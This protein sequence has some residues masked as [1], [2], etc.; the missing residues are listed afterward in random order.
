[1]GC[2]LDEFYSNCALLI[3]SLSTIVLY[4][5]LSSLVAICF[6]SVVSDQCGFQLQPKGTFAVCKTTGRFWCIS[7]LW[8]SCL[9]CLSPWRQQDHQNFCTYLPWRHALP[10]SFRFFIIANFIQEYHCVNFFLKVCEEQGIFQETEKR[11]CPY[12]PSARI[13]EPA[14]L[15]IFFFHNFPS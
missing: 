6:R 13:L 14:C 11:E 9:S 5:C 8:T 15:L 7:A 2:L 10:C 3:L 1:M 12:I 4:K